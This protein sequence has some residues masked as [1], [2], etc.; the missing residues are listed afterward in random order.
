MLGTYS[1]KRVTGLDVDKKLLTKRLACRLAFTQKVLDGQKLL[2]NT[3]K[4][5]KKRDKDIGKQPQRN[6][7]LCLISLLHN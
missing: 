4:Q 3:I 7:T 5:R 1:L 2:T 6:S